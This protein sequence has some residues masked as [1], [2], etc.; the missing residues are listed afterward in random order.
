MERYSTYPQTLLFILTSSLIVM[1]TIPSSSKKTLSKSQ[2]LQHLKQDTWVR[3]AKTKYGAGLKA[4]RPIPPNTLI[5]KTPFAS[6]PPD[7]WVRIEESDIK[8]LP[9][10]VRQLVYDFGAISGGP[11]AQKG[12]AV[13]PLMGFNSMNITN[14]LNHSPNP[15][16]KAIV[17]NQRSK[18]PCFMTFKT[19][20]HIKTGEDITYNY[21]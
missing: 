9:K 3:M 16:C 4:I 10:A 13:V 18:S 7:N 17:H 1:F 11:L 14:Y 5:F 12:P 21:A 20:R 6:C 15:N 19:I 2:L 8:K